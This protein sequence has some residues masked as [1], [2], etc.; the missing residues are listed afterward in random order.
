MRYNAFMQAVE[1]LAGLL[2][3][4]RVG[5]AFTGAGISTESG[6]P[7]FRSPGGIWARHRPVMYDD[8]I[9]SRAERVRYWKMRR[10]LYR[11]CAGAQPNDGHR[12]VVRLEELGHIICVVT[13]NIDGLHQE[14]GSR[15]VLEVHG[16]NRRV[17]CVGCGK[18][19]APEDVLAMIDA[20]D[21]APDC[22][23]C[24]RP[25]KSTTVAFGQAMPV[26]IM[27]EAA[28]LS[29]QADVYLAIGSSLAVEPAAS[30]PRIA[31]YHGAKL[32]I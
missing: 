8:F 12:A 25:L 7:D 27:A 26:E 20:G 15:R 31:K 16:N 17:A 5:V 28:R 11:E 9:R 29:E 6:I 23:E 1:Q 2:S 24:G 3:A 4:A 10:E 22:D 14:A 21:D 18:E 13:Q 32:V 30:L 19:W